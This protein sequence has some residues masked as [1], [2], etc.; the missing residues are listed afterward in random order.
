MSF[1]FR[2]TV[3]VSV[4][5]AVAIAGTSFLVYVTYKH[6]L[7]GQV[8]NQLSDATAQLPA[9]IAIA[10]QQSGRVRGSVAR[11][12]RDGGP[13]T[14]LLKNG[15]GQIVLPGSGQAF[16]IT[17]GPSVDG[18]TVVGGINGQTFSPSGPHFANKVIKGINS[19]VLTMS[20][21]GKRIQVARS[22]EEVDK[23]LAHLRWL[24]LVI[25]VAGI[26]V[27]A[28]LGAFVSR[29]AVA[30]LRRLTETTERIVETGDLSQRVGHRGR[31]EISRLGARLDELLG[32]LEAS[33]R[34]Q[35]QLV[36]DAS[37]E[38]RTPIATL[39]ANVELLA[40]PG[41]LEPQERTELLEDVQEELEA[42]TMLVGELV[43]LARGEE[44]DVAPRDFR[45]DE[46][47]QTAVDRAARRAPAV[48]FRTS[49]E[50]STV[51]G[52]P[53]RVERAVSNLLD[54]AR[55][56]SPAGGT[57]DVAVADGTVE[58]RDEGPGIAA[59]DRPL[60]FNRFYRSAAARGMPGAGL[61]LAIVKQI[62]DAHGGSIRV[63]SGPNGGAILRLQLS[64]SR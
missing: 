43:E 60:V 23:S 24:L 16:Q 35:R 26:G 11:F 40:A 30:P 15:S 59:E 46:V 25:S 17:I 19:R 29:R 49:L 47:V 64:S 38:L 57:V 34:S 5:V 39:R 48:A 61:G 32:T 37:H 8:D 2:L 9:P 63:D 42:M 4:A 58:V 56:W 3:L 54:N 27:A 21:A 33:L 36:A 55:K 52:V 31:D 10:F 1:R 6:E 12:Y 7:Y 18:T 41:E 51:R 62:A 44:Q 28:L 53:E 22:L 45:L 50:P 13:A 14:K 20:L